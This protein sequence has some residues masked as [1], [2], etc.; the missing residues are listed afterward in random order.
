MAMKTTQAWAWLTAGVLA[1]GLNGFYQDGGA[2]WAHRI[3]S[4]VAEQSGVLVDAASEQA[5]RLMEKTS[6]VA[7]RDETASCRLATA[8][9]RFQTGIARSQTGFARFEAMSARQEAVLARVE[10]QRAR[11][12]ARV[13]RVRVEP[14]AFN[15]AEI[16]VVVC[17]RLRLNVPRVNVPRVPVVNVPEPLVHVELGPGPI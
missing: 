5:D 2:A 13:A 9:V 15:T 3:V 6:L 17:P 1:L 4:Q 16:P 7:A 14:V 10:A 12:E 11:I 8:L